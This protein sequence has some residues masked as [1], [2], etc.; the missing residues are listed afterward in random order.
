VRF[1]VV[2]DQMSG[3][4]QCRLEIGLMTVPLHQLV[5]GAPDVSVRGQFRSN[6]VRQ[7][8]GD[9]SSNT[10]RASLDSSSASETAKSA[11]R[12]KSDS[13]QYGHRPTLMRHHTERPPAFGSIA[14][15]MGPTVA[16]RSARRPDRPPVAPASQPAG[17]TI[18]PV[19][20]A[21]GG[22][23]GRWKPPQTRLTVLSPFRFMTLDTRTLAGDV[24]RNQTLIL[25]L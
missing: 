4:A 12:P 21:Y 7:V 15:T 22:G 3:G 9:R 19:R 16:F 17:S 1:Q 14:H 5:G 11:R 18:S 6:Q 10:N 24:P 8:P 25:V 13:I 23:Q 2:L 20:A